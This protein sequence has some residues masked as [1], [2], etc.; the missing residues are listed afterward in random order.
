LVKNKIESIF[1]AI[2]FWPV[3]P[4]STPLSKNPKDYSSTG[5]A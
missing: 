5:T 3:P 2:K 1:L 4:Q